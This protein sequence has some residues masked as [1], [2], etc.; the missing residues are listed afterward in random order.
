MVSGSGNGI[1]YYFQSTAQPYN[2][3]PVQRLD[4][5]TSGLILV[6][7]QTHIQHRLIHADKKNFKHIYLAVVKGVVAFGS[8]L[9]ECPIARAPGSI[10]LRQVSSTGQPAITKYRRLRKL[11]QA[12][13]I[14][15]ELYTGRTHQIRVHMSHIG[16][17]LLGDDLYGGSVT[18]INRQALHAGKLLLTHPVSGQPIVISSP[19]PADFA[20]L[21]KQ[22]SLN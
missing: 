7:K 21:L 18:Q 22:L 11:H 5:N 4:R 20:T 1:M 6:A 13:L 12:S 2:I 17:P 16:H 9:I 19:L 15:L 10:I 14:E 3:H 8:H